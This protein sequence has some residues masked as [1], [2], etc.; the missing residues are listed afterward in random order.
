MF[1]G[2]S[3]FGDG[4][5]GPGK[6]TTLHFIGEICHPFMMTNDMPESIEISN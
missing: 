5:L 3:L 6:F 2:L 4:M 1:S